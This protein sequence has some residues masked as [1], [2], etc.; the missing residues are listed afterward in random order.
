MTEP[1]LHAVLGDIA[2]GVL[3]EAMARGGVAAGPIV[4]F[5][6]IDCLGPL[7][8]LGS[9]A[10]PASRAAYW[11]RLL[12][13]SSPSIAEFEEEEA[14]YARLG[15]AAARGPVLLWTGAHSSSRLWLERL[16][17]L[18]PA[19]PAALRRVHLA[20]AGPDGRRA[21]GQY[22]PREVAALLATAH[23]LDAAEI[24]RLARAW[25]EDAAV[26]SGVRRGS[27]EAIS[28]HGEDCCDDLL[29][30]ECRR[31]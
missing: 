11:A 5:R 10:G 26:A 20:G 29:L 28:H 27:G 14:R 17:S 1:I 31:E 22:E 21:L 25:Q 3:G 6:D 16:C 12:S 15:E 18:L 9:P 4:R 13:P 2:A 19:R 7:Q 23:S 24:A 30:A 8:A